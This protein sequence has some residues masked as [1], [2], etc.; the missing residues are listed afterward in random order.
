MEEGFLGL[1]VQSVGLDGADYELRPYQATVEGI[2]ELWERAGRHNFLFAEFSEGNR[3]LFISYFL[4]PG[5]VVI[6]AWKVSEDDGDQPVGILYADQFRPRHSARVHYFFWD[7]VQRTREPLIMA[8]LDWFM[9]EFELVRVGIE[10]PW[11]AYSALRRIYAMKFLPEGIRRG[12]IQFKGKWRDEILFGIRSGEF[13]EEDIIA[14]KIRKN[15]Q[16]DWFGLLD[17]EDTLARAIFKRD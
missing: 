2:E 12:S 9:R 15:E 14:G 4:Q 3:E 6:G 17:N 13:D 7:K 16:T 1:P 11:Y 8:A 10:V 5:V